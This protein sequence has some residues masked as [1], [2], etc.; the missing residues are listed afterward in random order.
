MRLQIWKV[1]GFMVI[2]KPVS[3]R[4][5][6]TNQRLNLWRIL[7]SYSTERRSSI[8]NKPAKRGSPNIR[9]K[10]MIVVW[11]LMTEWTSAEEAEG[12]LQ[13]VGRGDCE[14]LPLLLDKWKQHVRSEPRKENLCLRRDTVLTLMVLPFP[15][16]PLC[17]ISFLLLPIPCLHI[18]TPR[19]K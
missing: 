12:R 10:A 11:R 6:C 4:E 14:Q 8:K 13:R 16:G 9:R 19:L 7:S 1:V 18:P 15:L 3:S 17:Q 5:K 2:V